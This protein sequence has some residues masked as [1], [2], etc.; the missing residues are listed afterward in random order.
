MKKEEII[1][2][3]EATVAAYSNSPVWHK[4]DIEKYMQEYAQSLI[5]EKDGVIEELERKIQQLESNGT[6]DPEYYNH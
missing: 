5:K 4:K 1:S 6:N 3:T 2:I